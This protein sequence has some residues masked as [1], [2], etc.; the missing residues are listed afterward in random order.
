[1]IHTYATLFI[2]C[3]R[4]ETH[5]LTHTHQVQQYTAVCKAVY[6]SNSSVVFTLRLWSS[7]PIDNTAV[8]K[9]ATYSVPDTEQYVFIWMP[10]YLYK[11]YLS[12]MFYLQSTLL[13]RPTPCL[14]EILLCTPNTAI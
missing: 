13:A 9:S 4:Y 12:S 14:E 8:C 10:A 7:F 11:K 5:T 3:T 6:S 1:M 2:L